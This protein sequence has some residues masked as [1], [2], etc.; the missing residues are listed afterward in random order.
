MGEINRGSLPELVK[1][2]RQVGKSRGKSVKS[3][4]FPTFCSKSGK[5]EMLPDFPWFFPIFPDFS[6]CFWP[7]KEG[8]TRGKSQFS[9]ILSRKFK[10]SD[11][12]PIPILGQIGRG[13]LDLDPTRFLS[14]YY[15]PR[16]ISPIVD[17]DGLSSRSWQHVGTG[18]L[19]K[20]WSRLYR[21][22]GVPP[23][24]ISHIPGLLYK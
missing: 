8:K 15:P 6:R 16:D 21:D 20:S 4:L 10:D 19:L 18:E 1:F 13:H 24:F 7:K 17:W 3:R 2:S 11:L 5:V 9:P 14:R 12:D 23:W 22:R